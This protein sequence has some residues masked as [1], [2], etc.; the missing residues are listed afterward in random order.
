MR[1]SV[2]NLLSFYT[3]D[4]SSIPIVYAFPGSPVIRSIFDEEEKNKIRDMLKDPSFGSIVRLIENPSEEVS[5]LETILIALGIEVEKIDRILPNFEE[6]VLQGVKKHPNADSLMICSANGK[7][8]V[9]GDQTIKDGDRCILANIG[10]VIPITGKAL[11]KSKIRDIESEGMLCSAVE[12]L[13]EGDSE[14]V[15]KLEDGEDFR[16]KLMP[17]GPIFEVSITPNRGDL[18]CLHGIARDAYAFAFCELSDSKISLS[19]TSYE[20]YINIGYVPP[21]SESNVEI[22]SD[23]VKSMYF[24]K[25][26]NISDAELSR[27]MKRNLFEMGISPESPIADL[28][29]FFTRS[30][31]GQPISA[32]D[33]DLLGKLSFKIASVEDFEDQ[34]GQKFSLKEVLCMFSDDRCIQVCGVAD[35]KW[36]SASKNTKNV[37][38][39]A[40]NY[41]KEAIFRAESQLYSTDASKRFS[42]GIDPEKSLLTLCEVATIMK[43][44]FAGTVEFLQCAK[45]EVLQKRSFKVEKALEKTSEELFSRLGFEKM[46]PLDYSPPSWRNDIIVDECLETELMKYCDLI[47]ES[48]KNPSSGFFF[49]GT[50]DYLHELEYQEIPVFR[51]NSSKSKNADLR[52]IMATFGLYE[53]I[54][55]HFMSK[56]MNE[57]FLQIEK[58][59]LV[60]PMN[61]NQF[62]LRNSLLP[63]MLEVFSMYKRYNW[64]TRGVFEIGKIFTEEGEIEALGLSIAEKTDWL[65]GRFCYYNAKSIFENAVHFLYGQNLSVEIFSDMCFVDGCLWKFGGKTIAKFGKVN[66]L[67]QK[68]L[69]C[70]ESFYIGEI[71]LNQEPKFIP[72]KNLISEHEVITK[73]FSIIM[74]P[75]LPVDELLQTIRLALD[76]QHEAIEMSVFDLYP[77]AKLSNPDRSV[78]IRFCWHS[79]QKTLSSEEIRLT[80]DAISDCIREIGCKIKES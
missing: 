70:K 10:A 53:I 18:L 35:A 60:N 13:I 28:C 65:T 48:R 2:F 20:D 16:K 1:F 64:Q 9:C 58:Y 42:Y 27:F 46:G 52:I 61:Q 7:T 41:A 29:K 77:D 26:A 3:T 75:E 14:G 33:A 55:T 17:N 11:L 43:Q 24:L 67:M 57:I 32:F 63:S 45:K 38:L 56:S 50:P 15:I 22:N 39:Q 8:I 78:G 62:C 5:K 25:L 49:K 31:Y 23:S 4:V 73:D 71:I 69:K 6:V 36:A 68:K 44:I 59:C 30:Y 37:L 51:I 47:R 21:L 79:L 40:G 12:L 54:N 76:K 34:K 80:L 19:Q 66:P 72:E 74:K